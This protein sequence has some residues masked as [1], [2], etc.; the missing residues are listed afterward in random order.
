[1]RAVGV[2]F[3]SRGSNRLLYLMRNGSRHAMTW[4][5]PGGKSHA[6]ETLLDT[7]VRECQ[8]EI[9]IMPQYNY[10]CPIEQFTGGDGGFVYHTFFCEVAHEFEV[11]LNHENL[12]FAW[13]THGVWPRPMHP[14]LWQMVN[15]D[16]VMQKIS[17]VIGDSSNVAK[18]HELARGD[19]LEVFATAP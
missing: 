13:I 14:G 12:G 3:Y 15:L 4:G 6:G 2:W 19:M 16:D 8:E 7:M 10:M 18:R 1:M 5:L 11:R 9:G 17:C